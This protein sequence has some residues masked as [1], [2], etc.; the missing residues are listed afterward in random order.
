[1]A[2]NILSIYL[3]SSVIFLSIMFVY[4]YSRG[5]SAFAKA[6]GLLSLTLD[7]YLLGYLLEVN[8]ET[9]DSMMFWNQVQ[10]FG[11][12][13]FP[14]F[15]LMVSLLYTGRIKHLWSKTSI[16]VFIIPVMTFFMRLT[17]DMH[18]L[19]Y[20]NIGVN[21]LGD[22]TFLV[23]DKGPWYYAQ[24]FYSLIVLILCTAFYYQKLIKTTSQER[25][26]FELL[27]TASIIPY[28]ALVL[29][30]FDPGKLGI[31]Y[32]AIVLPLC[33]M[34]INY[35]L[36]RYNFLGLKQLA[37]ERVFEESHEGLILMDRHY[38]IRDFNVSSILYFSLFG[39]KLKNEDLGLVL[40]DHEEILNS[41]YSR[42]RSV[43]TIT[44]DNE[45]YY[46]EFSTKDIGRKDE[47]AGILLTV[48]DV[49]LSEKLE[50]QLR[51]LAQTDEL[52]GLNNRRYFMEETSKILDRALR[53][54]EKLSMLMMDIDHFKA[55][56]DT[57]GHA[58]GDLVL[59][60]LA[61]IIKTTYRSTDIVG[62]FGGEEFVVAMINTTAEEAYDRAESLRSAVEDLRI[63]CQ[64]NELRVTISIGIAELE[65]DRCEK[66]DEFLNFADSAMYQAKERGRNQT[67]IYS[68]HESSSL[69]HG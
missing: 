8:A 16:I 46:I 52:T 22:F 35:A 24:M 64:D 53:Y 43:H 36:S 41:I 6:F 29:I 40:K 3:F 27:F 4:S 60:T 55:I 2:R 57:Y 28:I 42:K 37:R 33:I 58:C 50:L 14:G 18:L 20:S 51:E 67:V 5:K 30:I 49:T 48:E 11:I 34:L 59:S 39:V 19:F 9:M 61:K 26:Q 10:Y 17:N 66:L 54:E 32:S 7:I 23:L 44:S 47:L 38:V 68:Q 31:D 65:K 12:P 45:Q 21:K 69:N 15:W 62:R 56:N 1:M 63:N 13:F 25:K